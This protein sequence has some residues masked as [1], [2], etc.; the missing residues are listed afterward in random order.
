M[1]SLSLQ[2]V[3][4]SLP[5]QIFLQL[6]KIE[7]VHAH[8]PMHLEIVTGLAFFSVL[9]SCVHTLQMQ[10]MQITCILLHTPLSIVLGFGLISL[11][12][13]FPHVVSS[14]TVSSSHTT[15]ER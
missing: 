4:L 5:E 10:Q 3:A 12:H 15:S 8:Q 1:S 13:S 2:F 14:H 9:I 6:F 11:V 7:H